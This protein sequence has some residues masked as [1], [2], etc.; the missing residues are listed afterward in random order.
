MYLLNVLILL[1]TIIN[2]RSEVSEE[3]NHFIQY[4]FFGRQ[5][6]EECGFTPDGHTNAVILS[7]LGQY[8]KCDFVYLNLYHTRPCSCCTASRMDHVQS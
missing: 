6:R 7:F 4:N 5:L 2:F 1:L 8:C 3:L